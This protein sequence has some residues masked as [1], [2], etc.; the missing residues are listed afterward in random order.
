[1]PRRA[2]SRTRA[3]T[4]AR[5][6]PRPGR[7]ASAAA[8][9]RPTRAGVPP[10]PRRPPG[11]AGTWSRASRPSSRWSPACWSGAAAGAA[12]GPRPPRSCWRAR[13]SPVP[14]AS[15]PRRGRDLSGLE[16]LFARS[17]AAA[18]YVRAVRELRYGGRPVRPRA[19][20][21]AAC[22]WSSLVVV[23]WWGACVLG[24]PCRRIRSPRDV[25]AASESASSMSCAPNAITR[26]PASRSRRGARDRRKL[27]GLAASLPSRSSSAEPRR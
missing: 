12:A 15:A 13:A 24:G 3:M 10:R 11:G 7:R 9:A 8:T 23:G 19:L 17:P 21:A 26:L 25:T 22:V 6:A 5:S 4:T 18:G 14:H 16:A 20:S 27:A 2:R 1:M